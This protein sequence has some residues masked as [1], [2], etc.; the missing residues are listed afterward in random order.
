M[1]L[2]VFMIVGAAAASIVAL[3]TLLRNSSSALHRWLFVLIFSACLWVVNVNLHSVV[4]ESLGVWLSR[5][6]FVAATILGYAILRF[7]A[8]LIS[9]TTHTLVR[10][11]MAGLAALGVIL[12]LSPLVIGGFVAGS[13]T[14]DFVEPLRGPGY[15]VVIGIILVLIVYGLF[16][17]HRKRRVAKGLRRT[18]LFM[19]EIGLVVGTIVGV[20]TN[21]VLP[22]LLRATYPSRFA[23]I[24]LAILTASLVY[25]VVRHRF[26]DIRLAVV[27]ALAYILSFLVV[28]IGYSAIV[29]AVSATFFAEDN[30]VSLAAQM[31]NVAAAI[32]IAFTLGPLQRFFSKLTRAIFYQDAYDTQQVLDQLGTLIVRE[33]DLTKLLRRSMQLLV[34]AIKSSSVEVVLLRDHQPSRV[35]ALGPTLK[36]AASLVADLRKHAGLVIADDYAERPGPIYDALVGAGVA[37]AA[38]LTTPNARIGYVLIS[39]K[40]NGNAFTA[41]DIE[42]IH[43]FADELAVAV[44]NAMRFD[45][46]SRFNVTLKEEVDDATGQLR[47]SN[48]KLHML[49]EA[50]DEFISMASHQLRTPLT[51]VKGYL[52]MVLEGDAGTITPDQRRLLEE[53]YSSSQRMVYLIGD[54]LNVS[55]LQTGKFMLELAQVDLVRLVSDEVEQ[56]KT[57]ANGRDI[58]LAF[59]APSQFPEVTIDDGK[60]RQVIMNFVDNAIFYS[61]P[62]STVTIELTASTRDITLAVHDTGIGVPPS[63]RHHL[64]TKF[65][66]ATNARKVRPDGTGIG[67]YMAKKVVTAHGGSIIFETKENQGSTFGFKLPLK[68]EVK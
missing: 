57:T 68:H 19:V 13:G 17:L 2:I 1:L 51:S 50:K 58:T 32:V 3:L 28:V 66:R 27:R 42:L 49:D 45:E 36:N 6:A 65:Y 39:Y 37:V 21:I 15:P 53:A 48:R 52:S 9:D 67:L 41:R 14:G 31:V 29:F 25:G 61:K 8:V 56:L 59:H 55:R 4:D 54:F 26:M 34:D 23:F 47:A 35:V 18:Q 7:C 11:G 20:T 12:S 40:A 22:N 44:Q 60:I 5:F 63:E 33:V 24:A 16:I 64:F 10:V 43:L 62:N 30:R 38:P 46:I